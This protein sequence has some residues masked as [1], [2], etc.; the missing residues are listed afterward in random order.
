[1]DETLGTDPE[2]TRE[3]LMLLVE[4]G[5]VVKTKDDLY[6]HAAAVDD[7]SHRRDRWRHCPETCNSSP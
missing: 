2:Q 5:V 6:F 4:E 7:L 3:V 1:M